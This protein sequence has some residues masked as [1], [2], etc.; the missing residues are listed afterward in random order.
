M[1]QEVD[2]RRIDHSIRRTRT[3]EI[4][5]AKGIPGS[6]QPSYVALRHD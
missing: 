2:R 5:A 3:A 4:R 1:Q 6:A